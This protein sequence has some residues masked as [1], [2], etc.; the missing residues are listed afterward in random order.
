MG[1]SLE[2]GITTRELDEIGRAALDK[3]GCR[4]APILMYNFPGATCISVNH[5]V[6]HGIPDDT[7]IQPGDMVHIDVS[8]ERDGVYAD[9][10]ASSTV[11][12][13][14]GRAPCADRVGR[15]V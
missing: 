12:P 4:S 9:T 1:A 14:T 15:Y 3:E 5:A 7:R 8:A 11:P 6:A 10:G 2:P 13:E